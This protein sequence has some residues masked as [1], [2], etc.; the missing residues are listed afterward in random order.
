[1]L[2]YS[3]EMFGRRSCFPV[4]QILSCVLNLGDL[5]SLW[6][7]RFHMSERKG[8]VRDWFTSDAR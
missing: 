5:P 3:L 2:D 6:F 8:A 1:M 4:R 7:Y